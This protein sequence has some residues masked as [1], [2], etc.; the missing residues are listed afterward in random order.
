MATKTKQSK[1][2]KTLKKSPA[3]ETATTNTTR[4]GDNNSLMY[5][6]IMNSFY[7][8]NRHI[9]NYN[10]KYKQHMEKDKLEDFLEYLKRQPNFD[11]IR[12]AYTI[13]GMVEKHRYDRLKEEYLKDKVYGK[14]DIHPSELPRKEVSNMESQSQQMYESMKEALERVLKDYVIDANEENKKESDKKGGE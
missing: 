3:E 1:E 2:I 12:E 14:K 10:K 5:E 13:V 8:M 9:C 4:K 7:D 11:K 6:T